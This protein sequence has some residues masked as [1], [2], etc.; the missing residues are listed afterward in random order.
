LFSKAVGKMSLR[1]EIL[2]I[3]CN[4]IKMPVYIH[5]QL[6]YTVVLQCVTFGINI[7]LV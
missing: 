3:I 2:F 7:V 5:K 6:D 1:L 4:K